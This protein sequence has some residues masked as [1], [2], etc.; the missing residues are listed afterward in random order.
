MNIS[1]KLLTFLCIIIGVVSP[2]LSGDV[3][4]NIDKN[5]SGLLE[6]SKNVIFQDEHYFYLQG[7]TYQRSTQTTYNNFYRCS[8]VGDKVRKCEKLVPSQ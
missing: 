2:A 4:E 6:D 1:I 3:F 5:M 8:K 7:A